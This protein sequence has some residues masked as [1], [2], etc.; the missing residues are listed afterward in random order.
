MKVLML[1]WEYPPKISGGL[2]IAS[3]GLAKGLTQSGVNVDFV[4]PQA[5]GLTSTKRL[6]LLDASD[7]PTKGTEITEVLEEITSEIKFLEVGTRL[8]PY[9]TRVEFEKIAYET[10]T[11]KKQIAEEVVLEKINLKGGYGPDLLQEIAKYSLAVVNACKN[12]KYDVIHAH[13]WMTYQAGVMAKAVTGA[14]LVVHVHSTEYDRSAF[15]IDPKIF[16]LEKKGLEKADVVV[17]VSGRV[18]KLLVKEY[19]L[20]SSK[21]QVVHNAISATDVKVKR[22]PRSIKQSPKVLFVGR[23]TDQKGPSR[24]L[25]IAL[26]LSRKIP[27]VTFT[28]VGDG[29][30]RSELEAKAEHAQ[31]ADKVKFT[32]FLSHKRALKTMSTHDLLLLPSMAEPFGLV[33]LEGALAGVPVIISKDA[34]VTEVVKSLKTIPYWDSHTWVKE[35]AS[36]LDKP[37][38]A[39]QYTDRLTKEVKRLNWKL[40]GEQVKDIYQSLK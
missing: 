38:K 40:V 13:D 24:F 1:G 23:L 6:Q 30:L 10:T 11:V 27:D 32:G 7:Y 34:G 33:A 19:D 31:I 36:M 3:Q 39:T 2:G 22:A 15:Q 5:K 4:L 35:S 14:P 9:L 17:T 12:A 18:K 28:I 26:E 29:H 20:K 37:S 16:E 21:V 25:D 8:M